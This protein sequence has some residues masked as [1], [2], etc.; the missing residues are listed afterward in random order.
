MSLNEDNVPTRAEIFA[1][2][3]SIARPPGKQTKAQ[4]AGRN[5][6]RR[7]ALKDALPVEVFKAIESDLPS[8][9]AWEIEVDDKDA[10]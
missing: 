8:Y 7:Q 1:I 10:P 9:L 3:N 2:L 4:K 6:L 5:G